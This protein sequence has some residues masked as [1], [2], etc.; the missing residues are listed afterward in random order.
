MINPC[1]KL[2][3]LRWIL[4][5]VSPF[6]RIVGCSYIVYFISFPSR[7]LN[8]IRYRYLNLWLYFIWDLHSTNKLLYGRTF[9]SR[10]ENFWLRF[11]PSRKDFKFNL[12]PARSNITYIRIFITSFKKIQIG[13]GW[14]FKKLNQNWFYYLLI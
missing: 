6:S 4:G 8:L 14:N 10:R 5:Y 2:H 3:W 11:V 1:L 9:T 7:L 13:S 12:Y